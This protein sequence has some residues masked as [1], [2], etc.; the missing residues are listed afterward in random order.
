MLTDAQR[1]EGWLEH[2]GGEES[3]VDFDDR[4]D[5]LIK[6]LAGQHGGQ[7]WPQFGC[8]AGVIGLLVT[9]PNVVAYRKEPTP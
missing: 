4:I 6:D 5:V 7:P 8:Q 2:D 1:A 9:W 3:P